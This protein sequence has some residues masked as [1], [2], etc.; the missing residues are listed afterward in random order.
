M[1]YGSYII[2]RYPAHMDLRLQNSLYALRARVTH[3]HTHTHTHSEAPPWGSAPDSRKR[4]DWL[5]SHSST[6]YGPFWCWFRGYVWYWLSKQCPVWI[7]NEIRCTWCW[8][9]V[10]LMFMLVLKSMDVDPHGTFDVGPSIDVQYEVKWKGIC[11]I[12]VMLF[13]RAPWPVGPDMG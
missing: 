7:T 11:F 8:F 12:R 1:S 13:Y 2:N 3:T 5:I 6:K 4:T 10:R 9:R